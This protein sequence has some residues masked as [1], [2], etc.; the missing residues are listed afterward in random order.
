MSADLQDA[1]DILKWGSTQPE[2]SAP[3]TPAQ[4]RALLDHLKT[5]TKRSKKENTDK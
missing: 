5:N 2:Q 1:L 4:C 3:L